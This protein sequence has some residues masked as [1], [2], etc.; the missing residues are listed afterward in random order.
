MS[1]KKVLIVAGL[2]LLL[3]VVAVVMLY[4]MIRLDSSADPEASGTEVPQQGTTETTERAE[5]TDGTEE[6]ER[7][8]TTDGTEESEGAE[9]NDGIQETESAETTGGTHESESV[10]TT[11][12]TEELQGGESTEPAEKPDEFENSTLDED[13]LGEW[14]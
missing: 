5:T 7:A 6:S 10:G 3:S 8:E 12:G 14:N 11:D 2:V 1:R 9:T 4:G 13:D